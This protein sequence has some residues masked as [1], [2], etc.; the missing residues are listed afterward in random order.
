M[1]VLKEWLFFVFPGLALGRGLGILGLLLVAH[2][3][4]KNGTRCQVK[5]AGG[6][7]QV[8]SQSRAT[9]GS[10]APRLQ[11]IEIGL[12]Y[13]CFQPG[14]PEF[15]Q[16][17]TCAIFV[18]SSYRTTHLRL[19]VWTKA[20]PCY[21]AMSFLRVFG[22][23]NILEMNSIRK[24]QQSPI[25]TRRKDIVTSGKVFVV[26]SGSCGDSWSWDLS[27]IHF[28]ELTCWS[29]LSVISSCWAKSSK[30]TCAGQQKTEK[31][32]KWTE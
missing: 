5:S 31:C 24:L 3:E 19:W 14:V 18:V 2:G 9:T 22:L 27:A 23:W 21:A 20:V 32:S 16:Q 28:L 15:K 6:K 29:W 17:K 12:L 7:Y 30:L 4:H 1:S 26:W 10:L 11:F 13:Q 25:R 8:D